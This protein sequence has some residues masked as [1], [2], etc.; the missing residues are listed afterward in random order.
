MADC[1]HPL[2]ALK[3]ESASVAPSGKLHVE[4]TCS[5]CFA[6]ATKEFAGRTPEAAPEWKEFEASITTSPDDDV[7]VRKDGKK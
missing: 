3:P 2:S 5:S 1:P 7:T 4:F 6:H